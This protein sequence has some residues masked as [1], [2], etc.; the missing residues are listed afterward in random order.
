MV[1]GIDLEITDLAESIPYILVNAMRDGETIVVRGLQALSGAI[2]WHFTH[3]AIHLVELIAKARR[4]DEAIYS[5]EL[6]EVMCSSREREVVTDFIEWRLLE[7]QI[8]DEL[9][10]SWVPPDIWDTYLDSLDESSPDMGLQSMGRLLGICS[11][12]KHADRRRH[13]GRG[14][15]IA[16]KAVAVRARNLNR[17]GAIGEEEAAQVFGLSCS[18]SE[19]KW[20]DLVYGDKQKVVSLR[21][22]SDMT[23]DLWVVN[24]DVIV[25]MGRIIGRSNEL[26]REMGI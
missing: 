25:A 2:M 14:Y 3:G 10:E 4:Q 13:I 17:D 18:D 1:S 26:M 24:R 8:D 11:L 19:R 22:F 20:L 6:A 5:G 15:Y 23:G 12:A 7:H 16:V 9:N 21:F